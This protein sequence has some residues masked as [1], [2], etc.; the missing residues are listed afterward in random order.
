MLNSG[1]VIQLDLGVPEG[2]EAGFRHRAVVITAQRI[3]DAQPNVIQ[4]VPLTSTVRGFAAEVTI[5]P[6]DVNGLRNQ[7]AA[8]CQHIR[9]VSTMRVDQ[10]TGNI[11]AAAVSQIRDTLGLIL[12]VPG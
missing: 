2:R 12:D 3:L 5:E 6:D 7:S 10:V 1:D 8:Q 4:V 9:A 11:G